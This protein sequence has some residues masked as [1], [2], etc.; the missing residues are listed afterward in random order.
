MRSLRQRL[1]RRVLWI[2]DRTL[3]VQSVEYK[4]ELDNK[5]DKVQ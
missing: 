3:S 5:A 2:T 4:P 1:R